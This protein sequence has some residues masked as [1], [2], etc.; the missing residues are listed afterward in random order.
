MKKVLF[1]ALLSLWLPVAAARAEDIT[2]TVKGMVCPFCAQGITKTFSK[3]P[4][5]KSVHVDL[6]KKTVKLETKEGASLSDDEIKTSI[7][8]SGY[9]VVKIERGDGA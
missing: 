6:E 4:P 8:D 9:D 1:A 3:K 7:A 2:V 5:I